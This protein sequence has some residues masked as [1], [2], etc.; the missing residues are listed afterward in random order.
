MVAMLSE[1]NKASKN[2]IIVEVSLETDQEVVK[3]ALD[4]PE[5]LSGCGLLLGRNLTS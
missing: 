4:E 3:C 1:A 5:P 2:L